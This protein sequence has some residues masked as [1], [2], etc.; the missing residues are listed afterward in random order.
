MSPFLVLLVVALGLIGLVSFQSL[1]ERKATSALLEQK[2]SDL[3]KIESQ[4]QE[5]VKAVQ[6]KDVA[7][8]LVEDERDFLKKKISEL[9]RYSESTQESLRST[10]KEKEKEVQ[11]ISEKHRKISEDHTKILDEVE[12]LKEQLRQKEG[13]IV[14]VRNQLQEYA[15]SKAR[16]SAEQ[17]A[18]EQSE[19]QNRESEDAK[20]AKE[21]KSRFEENTEIK[22]AK[23]VE[24]KSKVEEMKLP[25][26]AGIGDRSRVK[27]EEELQELRKE[28]ESFAVEKEMEERSKPTGM[29]IEEMSVQEVEKLTTNPEDKPGVVEQK[30][31]SSQE[32]IDEEQAGRVENEMV[33]KSEAINDT[34]QDTNDSLQD[35][36][37]EEQD[38]ADR[39]NESDEKDTLETGKGQDEE[40]RQELDTDLMTD[41]RSEHDESSKQQVDR[42]LE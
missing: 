39:R 38:L 9:E 22:E 41:L 2:Q 29:T 36:E 32:K 37:T 42:A 14:Y 31:E 11:K 34:L 5:H 10:L 24:E 15:F 6:T 7:L 33:T 18:K 3:G 30:G 17:L 1:K 13:E 12:Q 16:E 21:E 23:P 28:S 40:E 19:E 35:E 4:L 25:D 20:H 8:K 27:D 26:E